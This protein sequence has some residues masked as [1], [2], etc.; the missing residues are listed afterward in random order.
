MAIKGTG[1]VREL[2]FLLLLVVVISILPYFGVMAGWAISWILGL[3]VEAS[4]L[5]VLICGLFI[6][7]TLLFWVLRDKS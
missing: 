4:K 6:G 5:V 1:F 7:I 2:I 3:G